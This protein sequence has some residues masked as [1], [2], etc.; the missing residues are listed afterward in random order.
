MASGLPTG[1]LLVETSEL[2]QPDAFNRCFPLPTGADAPDLQQQNPNADLSSGSEQPVT[3]C[4]V[5]ERSDDDPTEQDGLTS[6]QSWHLSPEESGHY[7]VG[8][9]FEVSEAFNVLGF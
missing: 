4:M 3:G 6:W 2:D 8:C 1:G 7:S 9:D 5:S